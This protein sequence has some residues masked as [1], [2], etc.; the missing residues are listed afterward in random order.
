MSTIRFSALP[1]H[2]L[3]IVAAA[4]FLTQT[5]GWKSS[6]W[7]PVTIKGVADAV[8]VCEQTAFVV[9]GLFREF[10]DF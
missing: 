5:P 2:D 9:T 6:G 1:R 7:C 3:A 8:D 10:T 4:K